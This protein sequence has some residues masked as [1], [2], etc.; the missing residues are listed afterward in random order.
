MIKKLNLSNWMGHENLAIRFKKG[1]NLVFGRNASGKSSIA[2][3]IAFILTGNLPKNC[4]PRRNIAV[5]SIVDL[6]FS[7]IEGKD[8][9]IRRQTRKGSKKAD[10]FIYEEPNLSEAI[11]TS[12]EAENFIKNLLGMSGDIFER[13]IYMK[14]EDVHEFLAKPGGGV[15]NEIDRLI[16]LDKAHEINQSLYGLQKQ[17]DNQKNF[18]MKERKETEIAVRKSMA[19]EKDEFDVKKIDRRIKKIS[20]TEK[21]L[22]Q[23]RDNVSRQE[24][25]NEN[26]QRI[27]DDL[28]E[29]SVDELEPKLISILKKVEDEIISIEK[30][31]SQED[32]KK[33]TLE[34]V[35]AEKQAKT[36]LKKDI[37]IAFKK[38]IKNG[39][40]SECPT[41]QRDM[42]KKL[43]ENT[44]VKLENDIEEI[45]K[46]IEHQYTLIDNFRDDIG[47]LKLEF[48][49]LNRNFQRL[50][51]LKTYVS[52]QFQDFITIEN[53]IKRF[54][55]KKYPTTVSDINKQLTELNVEK[56]KLFEQ[57]GKA[58]GAKKVSEA[59][60]RKLQEKEVKAKH[61]IKIT[62]L[63]RKA[64][65]KTSDILRQEYSNEV[66]N[67]AEIIWE[68]YKGEPWVIR[69]DKKFVPIARS[70][71]S[72]RIQTAYE[73]SGSERFLILLAIRLAMLQT[74][75]QFQLLI[76]DE[77]CQHLD[78]DSGKAFRDIL[79]TIEGK[80]IRQSIVLTYNKN[81][82]DGDWSN[83]IK[84]S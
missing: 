75:D 80:K 10:I 37:I 32:K 66:M 82:L 67:L 70:R 24:E 35:L 81:F 14:E 62:E 9:L 30:K 55:D 50:R 1:K 40:I 77:P 29:Q 33:N 4:N 84:L 21:E 23:H 8:Y 31:I 46:E 2:K 25:L 44:I 43:A 76:I 48:Q 58:V 59:Q 52:Q 56:E 68:Q 16:G 36:G 19:V 69:W 60:I 5:E 65:L 7:T 72:E 79:T 38:Q 34:T 18:F 20:I 6:S 64:I 12:T 41:C 73:M 11:F 54:K 27:K 71:T 49:Q 13:V 53:L 17:L 47:K 45:N 15:L 83:V 3:A 26:L 39:E 51:E 61:N 57:K 74:I 22:I 63:I 42:D 28:N 78:E